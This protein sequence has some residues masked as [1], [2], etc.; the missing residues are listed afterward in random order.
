MFFL[1]GFLPWAMIFEKPEIRKEEENIDIFDE[2]TMDQQ[3]I[4]EETPIRP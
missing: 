4:Y 2:M 1:T 3:E